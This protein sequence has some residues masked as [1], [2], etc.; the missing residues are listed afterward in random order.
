MRRP[1]EGI[2]VLDLTQAY[3]GPFCTMNLADHGAEVIKIETPNGGDQ[4]RA[5][6]PLANDYSGYFAYIN[7]NKKG[8]TLDMK[9]PEGRELLYKLVNDA[10]EAIKWLNELGVGPQGFGGKTTAVGV[11]IEY[12][13]THIAG[14]PVAINICCHVNRHIEREL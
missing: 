5:W 10:P 14:L 6:G 1:L 9:V 12:F 8:I 2:R 7:R 4:T 13:P 3:S 11:N